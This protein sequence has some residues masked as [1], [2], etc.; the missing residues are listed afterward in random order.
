[1]SRCSP[2]GSAGIDIAKAGI[3]VTI[4]VPSDTRPGARQQETRSVAT[5]RRD[6]AGGLAAGLGG[7][8]GGDG[9]H[10]RYPGRKYEE[11]GHCPRRAVE[12]AGT[13]P[14]ELGDRGD[15]VLGVR[16]HFAGGADDVRVDDGRSAADLAAGAG[17][18]GSLMN[19]AKAAKTWK[20]SRPPGW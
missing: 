15:R 13:D 5:T 11:I 16:Q 4:R 3:E 8:Q 14:E 10:R 6:R 17:D 2:T 1:M 9:G 20:T 18:D 12:S 19:S 7:D